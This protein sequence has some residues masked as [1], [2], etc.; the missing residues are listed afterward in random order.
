MLPHTSRRACLAEKGPQGSYSRV[1]DTKFQENSE[2]YKR[3]GYHEQ[4]PHD[5]CQLRGARSKEAKAM[6]LLYSRGEGPAFAGN[7]PGYQAY[8]TLLGPNPERYVP[9]MSAARNRDRFRSAYCKSNATGENAG[10]T[11]YDPD[12]P[13]TNMYGCR[14]RGTEYRGDPNL[15]QANRLNVQKRHDMGMAP[16]RKPTDS[17]IH[18]RDSMRKAKGEAEARGLEFVAKD[19]FIDTANS[20]KQNTTGFGPNKELY[21]T[22]RYPGMYM[23]FDQGVV[24][25]LPQAQAQAQAREEDEAGEYGG[26]YNVGGQASATYDENDASMP[27]QMPGF[28]PITGITRPRR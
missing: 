13:E 26:D 3:R 22:G 20:W 16:G 25:V 28:A 19:H 24:L 23:S 27:M 15:R 17:N 5:R 4:E 12:A 8:K 6:N 9:S 14:A 21:K 1:S 11:V 2:M 18:M 10:L 7:M